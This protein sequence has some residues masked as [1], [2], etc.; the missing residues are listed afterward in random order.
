MTARTLTVSNQKGQEFVVYQQEF[1][2]YAIFE[3]ACRTWP[4]WEAY[5]VTDGEVVVEQVLNPRN[6]PDDFLP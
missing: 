4:D 2:G 3:M 6:L 5:T 1:D